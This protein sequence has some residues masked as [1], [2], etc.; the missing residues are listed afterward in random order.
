MIVASRD[1]RSES[2][3]VFG[4]HARGPEWSQGGAIWA[5]AANAAG[6]FRTALRPRPAR[7]DFPP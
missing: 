4:L 5:N 6:V 2:C 3:C 7:A 1:I